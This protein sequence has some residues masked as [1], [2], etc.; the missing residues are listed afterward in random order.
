[1]KASTTL[2]F[3]L[4]ALFATVC[5]VGVFLDSEPL[6]EFWVGSSLL[7]IGRKGLMEP[8]PKEE[9]KKTLLGVAIFVTILLTLPLLHLPPLRGP[10]GL[11]RAVLSGLLWIGWMAAI[12]YGW[13][14]EMHNARSLIQQ[15]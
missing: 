2:R 11:V 15:D 6:L 13:Q 3:C 9:A 8:I 7:L 4:A 5:C 1:M 12:F 14:R 10:H